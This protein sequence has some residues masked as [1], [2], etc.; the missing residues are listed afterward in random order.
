M[1]LL[2]LR[3]TRPRY[4]FV[5]SLAWNRQQCARSWELRTAIDLASLWV[6]QG[7]H[8]RGSMANI[9]EARGR[10]TQQ[11]C[12][13]PNTCWRALRPIRRIDRQ[14]LGQLAHR[15]PGEHLTGI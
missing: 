5:Q 2:C 14:T 13:Q 1:V 15:A 12:R 6:A 10:W 9:R 7:E 11:I 4:V 8:E 3:P